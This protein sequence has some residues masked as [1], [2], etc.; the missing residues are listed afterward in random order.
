M[1]VA[2]GGVRINSMSMTSPMTAEQ[3]LQMP[4]D[5]C[6]YELVAGELRVMSPTSLPHGKIALRIGRLLLDFAEEYDLGDVYV[7][8]GFVLQRDPDTVY[9]PDVSF[10]SKARLPQ[11]G[12]PGF[13][14]GVPELAVEVLSPDDRASEVDEKIDNYLAAGCTEV[15]IANP[16]RQTITIYRSKKDIEVKTADDEITGG[17]FLPGFSCPVIEMFKRKNE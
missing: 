14:D 8:A 12:A 16:L 13:Y 4:D 6:K 1:T 3:L 11:E 10:L 17:N 5:G 9:G 15:W 2:W 7:E